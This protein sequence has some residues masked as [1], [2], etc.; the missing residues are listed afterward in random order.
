MY[1]RVAVGMALLY[2]SGVG[3]CI[4]SRGMDGNA[5]RIGYVICVH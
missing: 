5:V 4:G 1:R 3:V 2:C